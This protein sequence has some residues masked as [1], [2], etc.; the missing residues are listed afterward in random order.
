MWTG[1]M[2][3]LTPVLAEERRTVLNAVA[4][5]LQAALLNLP[6]LPEGWTFEDLLEEYTSTPINLGIANA[7][8]ARVKSKHGVA[9]YRNKT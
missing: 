2:H 5:F 4:G 3:C 9:A 8:S 6:I 7:F 1:V